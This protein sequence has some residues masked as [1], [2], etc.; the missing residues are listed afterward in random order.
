MPELPEVETVV[1]YLEPHLL[2]KRV[3]RVRLP[4]SYKQAVA[5]HAPAALTRI[6]KEQKIRAVSRR[7]KFIVLTL[8]SGFLC[9]HLRMTGRLFV[10]ELDPAFRK[11][12]TATV[13]FQDG[14]SLYFHD[15]RKFGR[16]YY[17]S[18]LDEL[19]AR[20]GVEPLSKDFRAELLYALLRSRS[21]MLKPLLLDQKVIAGLG[22]IYVDEALWRAR[23]HPRR[24]SDGLNRKSSKALHQ[25]IRAVLRE[26]IR[27]NGTTFNSFY[28]GDGASGEFRTKLSVFGRQGE[29][30][31]RCA[32]TIVKMKVAQRG[33]HICP[34][35]Q[36]PPG[37]KNC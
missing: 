37:G 6:L 4:K 15:T 9:I 19:E 26:S 14:S 27:L 25:A 29:P 22:N 10:G 34:R 1:R 33:T 21:R 30:C 24:L 13:V 28:F 32:A 16:I 3:V 23:L 5:T 18:D 17:Y 11:H 36:R 8:D 20:L 12:V 7:A 35:C 31:P 2:G